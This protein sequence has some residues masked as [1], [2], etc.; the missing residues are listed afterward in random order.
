MPGNRNSGT[1]E[2][3]SPFFLYDE[4]LAPEIGRV[5][6][7]V[8]FS[9]EVGEKGKLDEVLIPEMG[10]KRQTWI[11]KDDRARV[12]HEDLILKAGISIVFMRGLSHHGRKRSSTVRNTINLKQQLLMLVIKLDS[13]QAEIASS[14]KPRFF[15]LF[16]RGRNKPEISKHSTLREVWKQLSGR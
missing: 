11:T 4:G 3:S 14:R 7:H 8:G 10:E 9:L 15:I 13:I 1:T 5:L 12:Q 6:A 16:M 2:P